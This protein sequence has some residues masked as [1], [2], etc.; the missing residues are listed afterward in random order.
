M[1]RAYVG[2]GAP[3]SGA[4]PMSAVGRLFAAAVMVASIGRPAAVRAVAHACASNPV[5]LAIPCH[6]VLR[7]DGELGGYRW[8]LARKRALLDAEHKM[9]R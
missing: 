7:T 4:L 8:G 2:R 6:R 3:L 9:K 1:A 5:A